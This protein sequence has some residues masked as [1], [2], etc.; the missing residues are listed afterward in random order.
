MQLFKPSMRLA[1]ILLIGAVAGVASISTWAS[2]QPAS[3]GAAETD[4]A[5]DLYRDGDKAFRAGRFEEARSAFLAAWALKKHWQIAATLGDTEART[6]RHRDAAEHMTFALREGESEMSAA[7]KESLRKALA[8]AKR[9]VGELKLEI[10]PAGADI[11]IDGAFVGRSPLADAV[12]LD[13]GTHVIEVKKVGHLARSEP[14]QARAGAATSLRVALDATAE[15][16]PPPAVPTSSSS[17]PPGSSPSPPTPP[18]EDG[19]EGGKS[20]PLIVGGSTVAV[21]GVALGI[22]FLA[23]GGGAA[24][25]RD[26]L[27]ASLEGSNPCGEGTANATECAEIEALDGDA[28]TWSVAGGIALGAGAAVGIAT[29]AYALW[30]TG[31]PSVT[32]RVHPAITS[33]HVGLRFVGAF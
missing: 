32:A 15:A 6:K 4:R 33:E 14:V 25:D 20:A 10:A 30:P 21:A 17:S 3:G 7:Q 11:T 1:R 22:G 31:T 26:A 8:E 12:F 28:A 16:S 29:L 9:H 23:L 19:Q 13:E 5:R 24:S 2:A 18:P 27:R